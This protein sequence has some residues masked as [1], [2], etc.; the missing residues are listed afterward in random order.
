M[1]RS[2]E[3]PTLTHVNATPPPLSPPPSSEPRAVEIT[4]VLDDTVLSVHHLSDPR[5]G[6]VRR[7]TWVLAAASLVG[8][9]L[10]ASQAYAALSTA[11]ANRVDLRRWLEHGAAPIDFRARR[12]HPLAD[13][14]AAL[15]L[16]AGFG[17]G[18]YAYL[19]AV[20]ERRRPDFRIGR[21]RGVDL[22][23]DSVDE[24]VLVAPSSQGLDFVFTPAPGMTAELTVDGKPRPLDDAPLMRGARIRASLGSLTLLVSSVAPP[25]GADLIAARLDR[26]AFGYAVASTAAHALL[27]LLFFLLPADASGYAS[28]DFYAARRAIA[29]SF[30]ALEDPKLEHERGDG[31]GGAGSE[32]PAPA[33]AGKSGAL[34]DREAVATEGKGKIKKVTE[35]PSLGPPPDSRSR[36]AGI[37]GV[38]HARRDALGALT[39]MSDFTSGLDDEDIRGGWRGDTFADSRGWGTGP[40]GDGPGGGG[41]QPGTIGSGPWR[42][43]PVSQSLRHG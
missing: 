14:G 40:D 22:P 43:P 8:F 13:V 2:P 32:K 35:T 20:R 15:G 4:A 37:L 28:D 27:V 6:R 31:D 1:S 7:A 3:L 33:E 9:G 17:L 25:R 34:G 30:K 5:G 41:P 36:S 24:H 18:G 10:F 23:C 16:V 29:I 26:R 19:R 12:L 39:A 21:A 11:R 38:I 42:G